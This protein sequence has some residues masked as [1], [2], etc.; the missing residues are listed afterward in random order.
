ME[1][2][3]TKGNWSYEFANDDYIIVADD[4]EGNNVIADVY[5]PEESK[6]NDEAKANAKLIAA[7]PE[8]LNA[9]KCILDF[10]EDDLENWAN[11]ESKI[12]ITILPVHLKQ[13]LSAIRKA[14]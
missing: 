6:S 11:G 2:K 3:H 12:E 13:A 7:A 14:Q 4:F 5:S 10:P 9:L 8:L 1:T